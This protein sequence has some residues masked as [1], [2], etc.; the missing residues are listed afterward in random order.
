MMPVDPQQYRPKGSTYWEAS[1]STTFRNA[2]MSAINGNADWVQLVT[3]SD[4]SESS[5]IEPYTD[6]TL[7][8]T[9]GTGFYDLNAYLRDMVPV[10][11]SATY[12]AR[13]SVF[14]LSSRTQ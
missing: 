14:L 7:Q 12:Y 3:W 1:N 8:R 5:Q 11:E 4:F 6:A 2:W 10:G 13:R 9:V